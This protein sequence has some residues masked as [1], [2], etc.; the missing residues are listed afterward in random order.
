M[1]TLGI[2]VLLT[3]EYWAFGRLSVFKLYNANPFFLPQLQEVATTGGVPTWSPLEGGGTF[4]RAQSRETLKLLPQLGRLAGPV[5]AGNLLYLLCLSVAAMFTFLLLRRTA[6]AGVFFGLAGAYIYANLSFEQLAIAPEYAVWVQTP[7]ILLVFVHV[8]PQSRRVSTTAAAVVGLSLLVGF[9]G[10]FARQTVWILLPFTPIVLLLA[11]PFRWSLVAWWGLF[12]GLTGALG[13]RVVYTILATN[14]FSDRAY[15][16]Y[17]GTSAGLTQ[18]LDWLWNLH[19][20]ALDQRQFVAVTVIFLGL[21][22]YLKEH[23]V[24][25]RVTR[26][27]LLAFVVLL[28]MDLAVWLT[29]WG[30]GDRGGP[31]VRSLSMRMQTVLWAY[32][33][34]AALLIA[35][36][37]PK[38][39]GITARGR[40]LVP[41]GT[42]VVIAML[43]GAGWLHASRV[44]ANIAAWLNNETIGVFLHYEPLRRLR[45]DDRSLFRVATVQSVRRGD[46]DLKPG[47]L[48]YYGFETSD[49]V[50]SNQIHVARRFWGMVL[51]QPAFPPSMALYLTAPVEPAGVQ[52]DRSFSLP[53]LSLMNT[54]YVVSRLPIV[55]TGSRLA[56]VHVPR[57]PMDDPPAGMS[58][59]RLGA[60]VRRNLAGGAFYIYRNL[61]AFDRVFLVSSA[62][63][64]PDEQALLD[65]LGAAS[66][67][68]LKESVFVLAR[69]AERLGRLE[70]DPA[71]RVS[72]DRYDGWRLEMSVATRAPAALVISNTFGPWWRCRT[73]AHEL[74]T[75]AAYYAWLGVRLPAGDQRVTCAI[76]LARFDLFGA[77]H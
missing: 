75:F 63:S 18:L 40:L 73:D 48:M 10:D 21:V 74:E 39:V 47:H 12:V 49:S 23:E 4:T 71:A 32:A 2:P 53:L 72:L 14:P 31:T 35:A 22:T 55:S 67:A 37:V 69:D 70:R 66:A 62:R 8:L 5:A 20:L 33:P 30:F 15:F 59:V 1:L 76:D 42:V 17:S 77:A 28:L 65:A 46:S 19:L 60:A 44:K 26:H 41:L 50:L 29:V 3:A 51:K 58:A 25:R 61:D 45:A 9:F 36:Q 43:V 68:E 13:A 38:D 34:L 54:K 16:A 57:D 6:G 64:F 56:P 27:V 24:R 52:F 7:L 11:R